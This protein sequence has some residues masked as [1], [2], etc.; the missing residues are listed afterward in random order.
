MIRKMV[1]DPLFVLIAGSAAA[2]AIVI[3]AAY[4]STQ[5]RTETVMT[6]ASPSPVESVQEEP[7]AVPVATGPEFSPVS[8]S[9]SE[10]ADSA[11]VSA[12]TPADQ[13]QETP[14]QAPPQI[15]NLATPTQ[16]PS[17]SPE[18]ITPVFEMPFQNQPVDQQATEIS[19]PF[20]A[21]SPDRPEEAPSPFPEETFSIAPQ[22]P[23]PT[24]VS[25]VANIAAPNTTAAIPSPVLVIAT[26]KRKQPKTRRISSPTSGVPRKRRSTKSKPA[27]QDRTSFGS[28]LSDDNQRK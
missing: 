4:K 24:D 3:F 14:Q 5:S 1:I 2:I 22:T 6:G 8:D 21:K 15:L 11:G 27:D 26:P 20:V 10:P 12:V 23:A 9:F 13:T 28:S 16:E 19:E 18:S 25:A 7:I 17:L